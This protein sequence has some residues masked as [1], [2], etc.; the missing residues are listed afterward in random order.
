MTMPPAAIITGAGSG[1][2]R[3]T[4]IRLADAGFRLALVGRNEST[5]EETL[6]LI[7]EQV[8]HAREA[9]TLPADMADEAQAMSVA[10]V[11]VQS[12]G[13]LDAIVNNAGMAKLLPIERTTI[14]EIHASFAVNA[15]G[16]ALLIARA[17]PFLCRAGRD[18]LAAGPCV[19]NVSTIGTADPFPGFFLYAAAKCTVE[20]FARS[21]ANEGKEH[22]V[23]GYAVAPGAV[24]TGMLR[25]LFPESMLP[26]SMTMEPEE[27]AAVIVQCLLGQ[28]DEPS[29]ATIY[30]RS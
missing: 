20:S 12:F 29:G 27:I 13:R 10:D 17:W 14:E 7:A 25:G 18:A 8:D 19:V 16:P 4:A 22:G 3:A 24:E 23:R 30:V 9:I 6:T 11:T 26:R 1:I 15:F 2:G 28:R 21:I 5:L